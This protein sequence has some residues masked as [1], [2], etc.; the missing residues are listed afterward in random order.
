M[1]T[2]RPISPAGAAVLAA[3]LAGGLWLGARSTGDRGGDDASATR[4]AIVGGG[5]TAGLLTLPVRTL[6]G[7]VTSLKTVSTPTV[8]MISSET[9]TFC[10]SALRDMGRIAA[11]RPLAGLRVVTLEGAAA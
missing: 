3:V 1:S 2:P 5:A 8:V 11:G 9:C 6:D 4:A 7:Q 10:K